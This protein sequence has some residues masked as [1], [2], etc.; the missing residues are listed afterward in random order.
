MDA[1]AGRTPASAVVTADG[2]GRLVT[3]IARI[4]RRAHQPVAGVADERRAGIADER[5]VVA[6]VEAARAARASA[7]SSLWSW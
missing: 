7:P 2:P 6:G 3:P 5:D 4:D 1:A